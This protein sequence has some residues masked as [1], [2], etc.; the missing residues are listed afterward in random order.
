MNLDQLQQKLLAAARAR[1]PAG[2]VPLGFERRVLARLRSSPAADPWAWWVRGFWQAA[3]S[4]AALSLLLGLWVLV[5]PTPG[6]T[7]E[8]LDQQLE[9]TVFAAVDEANESVW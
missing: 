6:A 2:D 1:P 9:N 7:A 8:P 5:A 4:C 3:A